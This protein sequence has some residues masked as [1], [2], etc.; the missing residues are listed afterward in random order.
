M[1]KVRLSKLQKKILL[2]LLSG[3]HQH[4][5]KWVVRSMGRST[6]AFK[7]F[8]W[9]K[10]NKYKENNRT[11]RLGYKWVNWKRVLNK[12][13]EYNKKQATLTRSLQLLAA[14]GFVYLLNN[15]GLV[16]VYSDTLSQRLDVEKTDYTVNRDKAL[17]EKRIKFEELKK[18]NPFYKDWTFDRY[19]DAP[20]VSAFGGHSTQRKV[21]ESWHGYR[22]NRNAVD[23]GLSKK[24]FKKAKELLKVKSGNKKQELTL[25]PYMSFAN[26]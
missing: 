15:F 20:M 18:T 6:L 16:S 23:I 13:P 22:V 25:R 14:N 19:F 9:Q 17:E 24:G 12:P 4:W 21:F 2:T 10:Y 8:N 1:S 26:K 5:A 7:V 3:D 11:A